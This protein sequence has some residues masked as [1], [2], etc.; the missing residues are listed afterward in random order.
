MFFTSKFINYASAMT[1][2]LMFWFPQSILTK[3]HPGNSRFMR[4]HHLHRCCCPITT[5]SSP[6]LSIDCLY[7]TASNGNQ[8]RSNSLRSFLC[9]SEAKYRSNLGKMLTRTDLNSL[10]FPFFSWFGKFLR[11]CERTTFRRIGSL[12]KEDK[13][14]LGKAM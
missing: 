1:A 10:S 7:L 13:L 11:F 9:N 14:N 4:C 5:A 3:S 6:F 2:L 8:K 12:K